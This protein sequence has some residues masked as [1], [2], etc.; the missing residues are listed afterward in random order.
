[1]HILILRDLFYYKI[2]EHVIE[3]KFHTI[4]LK[5]Q[6]SLFLREYLLIA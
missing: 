1:M 2:L 6:P 4:L 5:R 3:M